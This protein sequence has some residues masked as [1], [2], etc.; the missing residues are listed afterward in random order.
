MSS[1]IPALATRTSTGP[2]AASTAVNAASTV[3]VG[4]VALHAEQPVRR[5]AAAMRDRDLVAGGGE[6][7]RDREADAAVAARDQH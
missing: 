1:V 5:A 4:H 3:A 2:C 6:R 7:P